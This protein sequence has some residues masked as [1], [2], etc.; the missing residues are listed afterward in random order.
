MP[1]AAGVLFHEAIGHRLEGHRQD[2]PEEGQTFAGQVGEEIIPSFLS[3]VD[4][5]GQE[6]WEG[7]PLNGAYVFDDEGIRAQRVSLVERGVLRNFLMGRKP[8]P[9][10]PHSNGHGRAQGNLVPVGRMGNLMIQSEKS[11]SLEDLKKRLLEEVRAQGKPFGL[12][13]GDVTGGSTNTMNYGYQAFKGGATQV[14]TIDAK[15]GE[16]RLVRGVEIVGTPLSTLN[17]VVAAS[18]TTGVFNGYCGAES[19][20]VPVSTIAPAL[21]LEE[22]ETQRAT[23]HAARPLVGSPEM[24]TVNRM[25]IRAHGVTDVGLVRA[26]NGGQSRASA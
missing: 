15:S 20:N 2:D 17:K 18:R 5:P 25:N 14:Y 9:D 7:T 13:I 23:A 21:L 19:G 12:L 3:V 6:E 26:Q 1:R 16:M 4:D 24:E 8:L 22:I 10:M 11:V